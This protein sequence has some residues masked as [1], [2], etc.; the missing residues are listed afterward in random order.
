[1]NEHPYL[2]FGPTSD[3]VG[4]GALVLGVVCLV[5]AFVRIPKLDAALERMPGRW[6][7]GGLALGA[8]AISSLYVV[9]YLRGGPRIIDATAYWLEARVFSTGQFAFD[10]PE[11]SGS[12]RGRFLLPTP[13]DRLGV[14]FPPGYPLLLAAG[15]LA[16]VP[17]AV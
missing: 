14:I 13:D 16:G 2:T 11:P 5:L 9:H 1:M 15:F 6:F 10:V 7:V 17:L 3:G 12:F 4:I 8:V